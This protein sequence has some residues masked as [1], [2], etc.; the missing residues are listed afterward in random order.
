MIRRG[1]SEVPLG[2]DIAV[3]SPNEDCRTGLSGRNYEDGGTQM[4]Q[5]HKTVYKRG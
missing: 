2:L 4:T 5:L 3:E 1:S